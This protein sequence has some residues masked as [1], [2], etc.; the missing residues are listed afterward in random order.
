MARKDRFPF[1]SPVSLTATLLALSFLS[2]AGCKDSQSDEEAESIGEFAVERIDNANA[3]AR[4]ISLGQITVSSSGNMLFLLRNIGGKEITDIT[5]GTSAT[6]AI[7]AESFVIS[8]SKIQ[9]LLPES[10]SSILTL[11]RIDINH[12]LING[13]VGQYNYLDPL[14]ENVVVTITGTSNGEEVRLDCDLSLRVN[15]ADFA[16]ESSDDG[17]L[18][19]KELSFTPEINGLSMPSFLASI[20]A[21]DNTRIRNVGNVDL[22]IQQFSTFNGTPSTTIPWDSLSPGQSV[23]VGKAIYDMG[24]GMKNQLFLIDTLGVV[25]DPK[26]TS[27]QFMPGTSIVWTGNS[28]SRVV[29]K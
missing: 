12:G 28:C 2:L 5:I 24:N 21:I 18:T 23:A 14:L 11:V 19:W 9:S 10:E 1:F 17:G 8:P 6:T 29:W 13:K 20:G 7:A 15:L 4:G 26:R 27:L 22:K 16:F 25:F 3:N